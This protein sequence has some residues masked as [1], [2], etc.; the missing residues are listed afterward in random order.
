[1]MC[2]QADTQGAK[3]LL[4]VSEKVSGFKQAMESTSKCRESGSS[5]SW[6]ACCGL[7]T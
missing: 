2:M 3:E 4:V 5:V 6:S 1:M 7:S